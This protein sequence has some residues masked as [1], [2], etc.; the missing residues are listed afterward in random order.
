[1]AN[2]IQTAIEKIASIGNE[3]AASSKEISEF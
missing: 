2:E 3:Q 1:M